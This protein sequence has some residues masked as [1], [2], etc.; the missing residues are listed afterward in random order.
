MVLIGENVTT[1][2][3]MTDVQLK[4]TILK[5]DATGKVIKTIPKEKN[6]A[7]EVFTK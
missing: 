2:L 7:A 5:F 4:H 1:P 3:N 6:T